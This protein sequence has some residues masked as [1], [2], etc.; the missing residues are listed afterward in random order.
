[1][2]GLKQEGARALCVSLPYRTVNKY[3]SSEDMPADPDS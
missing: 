1:M 2:K 3:A